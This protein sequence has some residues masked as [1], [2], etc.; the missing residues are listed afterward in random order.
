MTNNDK[1]MNIYIYIYIM[2]KH[3]YIYI[4][5]IADNNDS[6]KYIMYIIE[7]ALF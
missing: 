2:N 6:I 1:I 3:V 4:Q 7:L 5:D